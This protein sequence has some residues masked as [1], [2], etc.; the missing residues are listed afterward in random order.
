MSATLV[1]NSWTPLRKERLAD[2][3]ALA[4]A[5]SVREDAG[6]VQG[7]DLDRT[8][9]RVDHKRDFP[10]PCIVAHAFECMIL[11]TLVPCIHVCSFFA[12]MREKA[13]Q[14]CR[15]CFL[16]RLAGVCPISY[17]CFHSMNTTG[18][19]DLDEKLH[20]R[21]LEAVELK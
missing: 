2:L 11:L 6:T 15:S 1:G 12:R 10:V 4:W 18:I 3:T 5:C 17:A 19:K 21:V 16:F 14:R 9:M 20:L 7:A 13:V 8:R